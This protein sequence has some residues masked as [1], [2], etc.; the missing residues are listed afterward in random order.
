MYAP[1]VPDGYVGPQAVL[2]DSAK[3]HSSSKAD[4]FVAEQIDGANI[5]NSWHETLR[6]N[7]GRGVRMTPYFIKRPLVAEKPLKVAVKGI[8]HYAAPIQ[9]MFGTVYQIKGVVEF[10]P[11]ADTRYVVRGELGENYSAIWIEETA[12]QQLVGQKVE[13]QGVAK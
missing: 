5:D 4:F 7:Q 13:V 8:T 11:K 1:S 3:I 9:A 6:R 2:D 10:T 12:S